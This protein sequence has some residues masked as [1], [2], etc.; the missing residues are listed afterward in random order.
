MKQVNKPFFSAKPICIWPC[1]YP[2]FWLR[3]RTLDNKEYNSFRNLSYLF[4]TKRPK[5]MKAA[6]ISLATNDDENTRFSVKWQLIG[7]FFL[8]SSDP[9]SNF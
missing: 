4:H 9:L 1:P 6:D 3:S 2:I 5:G 8:L 7:H